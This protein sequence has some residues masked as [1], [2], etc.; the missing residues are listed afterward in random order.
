M[1]QKD[2]YARETS[3][4]PIRTTTTSIIIFTFVEMHHSDRAKLQFY[5]H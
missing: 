1:D 3:D 5:M 4:A 2:A